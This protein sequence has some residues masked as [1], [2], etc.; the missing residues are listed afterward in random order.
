MEATYY[1]FFITIM[2][3]NV[4]QYTLGWYR[5]RRLEQRVL[6]LENGTTIV[7][8]PLQQTTTATIIAPTPAPSTY[9]NPNYTY[10][11]PPMTTYGYYQQATAPPQAARYYP[12]DP[13]VQTGRIY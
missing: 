7:A 12:E 9:T 8:Q 2:C 10:A 1:G 3:L 6:L 5:V 4:L 11:Q 13:Q